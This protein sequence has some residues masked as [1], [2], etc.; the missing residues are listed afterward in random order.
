MKILVQEEELTISEGGTGGRKKRQRDSK[1]ELRKTLTRGVSV[2]SAERREIGPDWSSCVQAFSG[3]PRT[4]NQTSGPVQSIGRRL[5]RTCGP[6]RH[7]SGPN[8]SSEMNF[9]TTNKFGL[10]EPWT[11]K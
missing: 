7:R 10:G 5:N 11:K 8:R 6:V 4:L 9:P 1:K 2:E 3:S